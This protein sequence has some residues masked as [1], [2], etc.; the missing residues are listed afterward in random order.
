MRIYLIRLEIQTLTQAFLH[1]QPY[2]V[3]GRIQEGRGSGP[4]IPGKSQVA[5]GFFR[6]FRPLGSNCVTREVRFALCEIR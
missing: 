3:H 5:L 1:Q 2:F 6:I 4:P